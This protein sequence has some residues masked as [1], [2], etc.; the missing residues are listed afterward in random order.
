MAPPPLA[1]QLVAPVEGQVSV[2]ESPL[3]TEFA[4]LVRL[5]DSVA[6]ARFACVVTGDNARSKL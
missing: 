1:V 6:I 3:V 5:S 4:L 2:K